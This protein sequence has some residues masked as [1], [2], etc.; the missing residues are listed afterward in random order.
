MKN[1]ILKSSNIDPVKIWSTE[2]GT[3]SIYKRQNTG[4]VLKSYDL[5]DMMGTELGEFDTLEEAM[6][7]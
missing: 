1:Y 6:N 3:Y 2:D 7:Y 4:Y 5:F